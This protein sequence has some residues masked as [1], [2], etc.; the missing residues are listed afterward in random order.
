MLRPYGA[1]ATNEVGFRIEGIEP[2]ANCN[3][4]SAVVRFAATLSGSQTTSLYEG[5]IKLPKI[6]TATKDQSRPE[7][8]PFARGC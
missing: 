5:L 4:I 2:G 8:E 3:G 6:P 7:L 1:P